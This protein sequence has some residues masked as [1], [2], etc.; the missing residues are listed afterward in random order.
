MKDLAI[1]QKN[2]LVILKEIKRICEKHSIVY[3][4]SSGTLLGAIRHNGFIPWDDDIDVEMPLPDYKRFIEICKSEL[5][6]RFFLQNYLT[7]PNFHH[8]FTKI[9]MNNTTFIPAHH[10]KYH[11]HQGFWVDVFPVVKVPKNKLFFNFCKKLVVV[12]NYI[13]IGDFIHANYQEFEKKLGTIGINCIL[14]FNKLPIKI[15]V[16]FH[17]MILSIILRKPKM[18]RPLGIFWTTIDSIPPNTYCD[19][20]NWRFEDDYFN[21]PKEYDSYLRHLYGDYWI[22]PPENEQ[23]GHGGNFY[24]DEKKDYKD[25]LKSNDT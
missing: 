17:K 15:R 12:S 21:I 5:D 14:A 20:M 25:Y 6:N 4:L 22:L 9:R 19:L 24:V 7:E 16:N 13:Q 1:I 8:G 18:N 23:V 3:Y 10:T 11:I 2:E